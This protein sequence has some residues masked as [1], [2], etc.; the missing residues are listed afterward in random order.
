MKD[1]KVKTERK[2]RGKVREVRRRG[3]E[4]RDDER[5]L[6]GRETIYEEVDSDIDMD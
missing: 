1:R 4:R 3:S 2:K 5:N 6:I